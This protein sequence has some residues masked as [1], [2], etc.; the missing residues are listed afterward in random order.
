LD[1]SAQSQSQDSR[2]QLSSDID[3]L[4]RGLGFTKDDSSALTSDLARQVS[5]DK[6]Q[7]F[8]QSLGEEQRK[9][10]MQSSSDLLSSQQTYQELSQAQ[11][12]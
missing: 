9:Q 1:V 5:T 12:T 3:S 4:S 8:T 2:Q 11:Q 6:G 7:R 10:L